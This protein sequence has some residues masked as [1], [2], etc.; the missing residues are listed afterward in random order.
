VAA[1]AL[2]NKRFSAAVRLVGALSASRGAYCICMST[3]EITKFREMAEE[4]RRRAEQAINLLDKESWARAAA[5]WAT[6]AECAERAE[7]PN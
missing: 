5:E 4:C 6:L 7:K 3:D 2:E 1:S